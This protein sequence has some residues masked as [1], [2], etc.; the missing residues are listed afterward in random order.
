[1]KYIAILD[2]DE[3]EDF[4]FFKDENGEYLRALDAGAVN[5]EW[6]YLPFKPLAQESRKDNMQPDSCENHTAIPIEE[7]EKAKEE[8]SKS[9]YKACITDDG[10]IRE[11]KVLEILDKLVGGE[12]I[13]FH[14]RPKWIPVSEK[15]PKIHNYSENYLVTLECDRVDIAMFTECD[16]KHWWSDDNVIAWMPLP[17]ACNLGGRDK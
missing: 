8:I 16:G 5:G 7:I 17:E 10:V 3:Y 11:S 2:T 13:D 6:I 9:C 1:M 4:D 12:K 15:L 14:C